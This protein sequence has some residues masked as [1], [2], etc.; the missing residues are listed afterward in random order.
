MAG[1]I[2]VAQSAHEHIIN[3]RV[4]SLNYND[5]LCHPPSL[6]SSQSAPIQHACTCTNGHSSNSVTSTCAIHGARRMFDLWTLMDNQQQH[7]QSPTSNENSKE[8]SPT[9]NIP[10]YRINRIRY[11][12]YIDDLNI[13]GNDPIAMEMVQNEYL[14]A[15]NSIG[16]PAKPSKI[17]RPTDGDIECLGMTVNGRSGDVGVSVKKIHQLRLD[18]LALLEHETCTG[19]TMA[20]IIG[21]W[22]WCAMARRPLLSVFSSVYRFILISKGRQ[23]P[24]WSSVRRELQC[25]AM[26]APLLYTNIRSSF[27]DRVIAS[28]ASEFAQGVV[29]TTSIPSSSI[30]DIATSPVHP[31]DDRCINTLLTHSSVTSANWSRVVSS[32]WQRTEHINSLELRASLTA[33]RWH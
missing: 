20:H 11:S 7:Q 23:Y 12:V 15:M 21:R 6:L 9:S 4:P 19:T 2:F 22:T 30:I 16:L 32:A 28:D 26:L 5:R 17:V 14:A 25:V 24:M 8:K 31:G 3:T 1:D 33:I 29:S 13:Y 18:T 27:M 10:D